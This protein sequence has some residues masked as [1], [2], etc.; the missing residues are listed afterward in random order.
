MHGGTEMRAAPP[1]WRRAVDP[2]TNIPSAAERHRKE[3][4]EAFFS[5]LAPR[6]PTGPRPQQ[7]TSA[8]GALAGGAQWLM[9]PFAGAIESLWDRPVSETLQTEAGVPK[10]Y[11]DPIGFYSSLALP[12][13]GFGG[14]L[15]SKG[16]TA[17][18]AID[19]AM[20]QRFDKKVDPSQWQGFRGTQAQK[21]GA[22][23]FLTEGDVVY[24]RLHLNVRPK[25]G[26]KTGTDFFTTI[27]HGKKKSPQADYNT[28]PWGYD[29]GLALKN[30]HFDVDQPGRVLIAGREKTKHPIASVGGN[31]R[32]LK[33]ASAEREIRKADVVA[34][35]NPAR[36]NFFVDVK[37]NAPVKSA[38][39]AVLL[40]DKVYLTGNVKYWERGDIPPSMEQHILRTDF[41]INWERETSAAI[42]RS[43]AGPYKSDLFD[44]SRYGD[45]PGQ[46]Q[47]PI[48]R[49]KLTDYQQEKWD[50]LITPAN[51]KQTIKHVDEGLAHGGFEWYDLEP[52]RYRFLE[53]LGPKVGNQRFTEFVQMVGALSP[54]SR[55]P[56]NIR[57]A[58]YFYHLLQNSKNPVAAI[59]KWKQGVPTGLGHERHWKL[60]TPGLEQTYGHPFNYGLLTNKAGMNQ[61]KTS[62]FSHN[63]MGNWEPTAMDLHMM[64]MMTGGKITGSAE[65]AAYAHPEG[66][67]VNIAKQFGV[68]PAQAQASGWTGFTGYKDT[69]FL[70]LFEGIIKKT[71]DKLGKTPDQ[72]L[73]LWMNGKVPLASVLP[74]GATQ[75]G[76]ELAD[77]IF[78][79]KLIG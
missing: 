15:A 36:G 53:E 18:K 20:R 19:R 23:K 6:D 61:P 76:T 79:E 30:A 42:A 21:V 52:L 35:F 54:G 1:L 27:H 3:G 40:G 50:K 70:V 14:V 43:K 31:Y 64:R 45:V 57:R 38:D 67:T 66:H 73:K 4:A 75:L 60:H 22:E 58:A 11:A 78:G 34:S 65:K 29:Q 46:P 44:F 77:D 25:K 13:V 71:A 16:P 26:E 37:T 32:P 33:P 7:I 72:V 10:E 41:P 9:S 55:V 62:G 69:P 74:M 48:P 47:F 59:T 49:I 28:S 8:G 5:G 39:K 2:L 24:G 51:L 63:L 68:T 12:G 56:I 17:M